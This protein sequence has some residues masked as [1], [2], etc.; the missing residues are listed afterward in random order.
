M[1]FIETSEEKPKP[2]Q[3]GYWLRNFGIQGILNQ[4]TGL[5]VGK[6]KNYTEDEKF[7]LAEIVKRITLEEFGRKDLNIVMSLDIGHTD[8]RHILPLGIQI[9]LDPDA[10]ELKYLELPF[11]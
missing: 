8:P 11:I 5:I 1:L 2:D 7:E 4:I 9:S 3:V 10:E 6:P